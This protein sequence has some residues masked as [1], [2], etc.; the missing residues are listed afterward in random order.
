MNRLSITAAALS[1]MESLKIKGGV[2]VG[3]TTPL[4]IDFVCV[5]R[6]LTDP[7]CPCTPIPMDHLCELTHPKD[8]YIEPYERCIAN[9]ACDPDD[10]MCI[11]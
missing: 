7:D 1:E 4:N 11:N 10:R 3:G 6:C 2:S 5:N 9:P 8:C